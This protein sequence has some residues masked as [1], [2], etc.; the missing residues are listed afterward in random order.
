MSRVQPLF[1]STTFM[2]LNEENLFRRGGTTFGRVKLG[3]KEYRGHVG[4][5][6]KSRHSYF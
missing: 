4:D 2:A 1:K 5:I 6:F 3:D